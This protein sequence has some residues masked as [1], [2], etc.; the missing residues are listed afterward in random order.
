VTHHSEAA[1][2]HSILLAEDFPEFMIRLLGLLSP[3]GCEIASAVNGADAIDY[4][5]DMTN[6][7]HLLITDLDMPKRTGWHV[8][9][10]VRKHRGEGVP[11]IMQTGE[12]TYPWVKVQAKELG[13][14][15]IHKPDIDLF[16]VP[17]V[18]RALGLDLA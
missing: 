18:H 16:L 11:I 4:V 9:E 10:A 12:A 1:A 14:V 3:I 13:I 8:I 6:P 5:R 17:A 2:C 7:L 15:L